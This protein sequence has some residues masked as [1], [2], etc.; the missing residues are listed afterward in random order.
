MRFYIFTRRSIIASAITDQLASTTI[1]GWE[2]C[3]HCTHAGKWTVVSPGALPFCVPHGRQKRRG[4]A[5]LSK[6]HQG[7]AET[8]EPRLPGSD[9]FRLPPHRRCGHRDSL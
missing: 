2:A 5:A 7:G 6:V 3:H 9:R 1:V 4:E 8:P